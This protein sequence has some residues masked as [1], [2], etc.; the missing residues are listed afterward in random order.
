MSLRARVLVG[1]AFVAVVLGIVSLVVTTT[2]RDQL[3]DQVDQRLYE[4]DTPGGREGPPLPPVDDPGGED[5]PDYGSGEV[6]QAI[7][8][9]GEERRLSNVR[10]DGVVVSPPDLDA[11]LDLQG[12]AEF[13]T[14]SSQ[15]GSL[16]Y[17]V[18]LR[19]GEPA[20]S[21]SAVPIDEVLTTI[22]RLIV[23]TLVGS[24]AILVALGL[25]AWWVVRLGV[26]PLKA[27]TATA[28]RIADGDHDVRIPEQDERTESGE[29]AVAL[30][31]MVGS[32][33]TALDERTRS[34]ERIRQ[35]VADASHELR[36]PVTTIRGYAELYRHGGLADPHALE[37]AMR[38]TE[39]EA[40]RMGRL[41]EDML[42]LARLDERR[43]LE[44][45]PVDLAALAQD[46]G[47]DAAAVAPR[48]A[49]TVV[50]DEPIV[51][52]GDED[53]LRQVIANVVGNAL[54]HTDDDVPVALRVGRDAGE[55]WFEVADEGAGMTPEVA[56]RATERFFR[57][58]PAR[59]RHRG[60]S[61][62]GLSIVDAAV[63]AHGGRVEVTSE[64]GRGTR[65]RLVL[66]AG[67]EGPQPVANS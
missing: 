40:A 37:D 62:L 9:N 67:A 26:R 54:V 31:R 48:R 18:L 23:V 28:K 41:V 16:T 8:V 44:R 42:A 14:V 47:A 33:T 58:D 25:V 39:Q 4:L 63:A 1:L 29:L 46:A 51:V 32:I 49:V 55:A 10:R 12:D 11:E 22:R 20:T 3:M 19:G 45:R 43:A 2:T 27:M 35:F 15:D 56:A 24:A 30:N 66:P 36:T 53:R 17:R 61:G 60:G 5:P 65:V 52:V 34:E 13:R 59:S 64:V 38:R 6:Y 57:A 7:R 50:A 21:I